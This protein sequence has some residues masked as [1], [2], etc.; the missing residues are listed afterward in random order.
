M[1]LDTA[2]DLARALGSRFVNAGHVGHINVDSGHGPWPQ[3]EALLKEL[4]HRNLK[5]TKYTKS[6][7]INFAKKEPSRI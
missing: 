5:L 2:E 7:F 1:T 6:I 4:I 3:G